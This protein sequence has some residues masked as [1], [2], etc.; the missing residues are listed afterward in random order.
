MTARQEKFNDSGSETMPGSNPDD[1][2]KNVPDSSAEFSICPRCRHKSLFLDPDTGELAC[3]DP[4]CGIVST[5]EKLA[6]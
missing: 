2:G 5:E 4:E 1:L 6:Q 3:L